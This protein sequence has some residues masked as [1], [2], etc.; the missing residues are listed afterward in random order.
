[1][2]IENNT[3]VSIRYIMK[4]G[5]GEVLENIMDKQPTQYLHGTGNILP[6]LESGLAGAQQGENK[7]IILLMETG[8]G[9]T[10]QFHFDI[11]IDEVRSATEA[12]IEQGKPVE[13]PVKN[14]C[15]PGCCC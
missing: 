7:S 4:T 8:V 13:V 14:Q 2:K 10:N 15:G 9:S 5:E 11:T 12:E 6:A 1:M 3:V